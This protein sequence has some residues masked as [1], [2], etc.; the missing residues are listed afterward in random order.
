M[1]RTVVQGA[2][3]PIPFLPCRRGAVR[4]ARLS[5]LAAATALA[6]AALAQTA[7]AP[8]NPK[9]APPAAPAKPAAA[10][11]KPASTAPKAAAPTAGAAAAAA[12]APATS[13]GK[14]IMT[15]EELRVCLQR[16]D[17]LKARSKEIDDRAIAINNER[18]EIEQSLDAVRADRATVESRAAELKGFEPRVVE[19]RKRVEEFNSRM[20]ELSGKQRM[21]RT[22]GIELE[23]LRKQIPKLEADR[24]ALNQERERLVARYEEAV[25]A[26]TVRAKAAEDRA[27][28]WNQR[29][30]RHT[31]DTQD[32]STAAADWQRECGDRPYR[33]DDEKAIRA[34]K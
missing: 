29:K 9:P 25:K 22:E 34:G 4:L 32:V 30:A 19:Y 13:G 5:V 33:E 27:A 16:N 2:V 1:I 10:A 31:Q 3:G 15:R 11:P 14:K 18:P 24:V 28:D 12:T 21:T 17:E 6:T 26:F 20:G 8:A 7:P 23:D